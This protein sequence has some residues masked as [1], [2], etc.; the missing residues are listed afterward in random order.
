M[1]AFSTIPTKNN[2]LEI[3]PTFNPLEWVDARLFFLVFCL[4]NIGIAF[5][6]RDLL[7]TDSMYYA[8]YSERLSYE[9]IQ[10]I[11]DTRQ[12]YEWLIFVFTPLSYLLQFSL[13]TVCLL[14]GA[15]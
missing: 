12:K 10:Q 11:L 4:L 14:V 6:Y 2:F 8:A 15:V 3:Q 5:L 7:I 1:K 9:R 13:V